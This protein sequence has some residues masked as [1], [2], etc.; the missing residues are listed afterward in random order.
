MSLPR[1]ALIAVTSA[2]A[3]LCLDR[4]ETGNRDA[5]HHGAS[6]LTAFTGMFVTEALHPFNIFREAGFEVVLVSETGTY[7]AVWLSQQKDELP[8][9]DPKVWEDPSSEFR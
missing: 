9:E 5:A 3:L 6:R 1:K 2:H 7:Q 8:G 4:K